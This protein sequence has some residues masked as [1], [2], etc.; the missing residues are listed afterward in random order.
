MEDVTKLSEEAV[1]RYFNTLSAFGYKSYD[2]VNKLLLLLLLDE[3]LKEPFSYNVTEED[4]KAITNSINCLYGSTCLIDFPVYE[5]YDS[6][7]HDIN[8]NYKIRSSQDDLL[9]FTQNSHIRTEA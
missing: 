4:Y 7:I 2:D 6:I 8:T 1:R 5:S 9:R 3:L